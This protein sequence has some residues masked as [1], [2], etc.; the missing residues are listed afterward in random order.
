MKTEQLSHIEL[1]FHEGAS[2]K[3]YRAGIEE[4]DGGFVV[5]F[6]FG[7]H[8]TTLNT[9]TKTTRPVPY[10]EAASIYEK[11]VRSKTAKGYKPVGGAQTGAGILR[12]PA[13][14]GHRQRHSVAGCVRAV[15]VGSRAYA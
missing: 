3:V 13:R 6:A 7:R 2:D 9:G 1:E 14:C 10:D 15:R 8:G 5:N 12:V 4:A 11:L